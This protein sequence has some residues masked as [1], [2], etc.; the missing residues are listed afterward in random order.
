M[1]RVNYLGVCGKLVIF[2]SM[3]GNK[4][5]RR[6]VLQ[7]LFWEATLRCNMECRHCGSDCLKVS[8]TADMP[9]ADFLPV[10]DEIKAAQPGRLPY[11]FTLGGEPLV[12]P[13]ILRCGREITERGF[14]WGM[15]SN[16]MLIDGEMMRAL[17]ANGLRSLAID[18]D[19][20]AAEHNWLR[21]NDSAF[22]RVF[23][24]ISHI[25]KAPHLIWDVITCVHSRNIA[26]LPE[27]R[28]MLVDAGVKRWRCFTIVPMGRAK[29]NPEL[30]LTDSQFTELMEF[31][32]QTRA[33]GQIDLS[34]SCEGY[35]GD[36][37]MRVRPY[38]FHCQAGEAVA[39]IRGNGDISGCLSIRSAY[40]QGNIYRDS[41]WD[42]WTSRF[43]FCRD[44]EWMRTGV[45]ADCDVFDR[46]QGNGMHLR[47]DDGS[48]MHCNYRRLQGLSAMQD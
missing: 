28:R 21:R 20:T 16:A 39:S 36:Y 4:K 47:R 22:D 17:S 33:G 15:V 18:V 31:I 10:L 43:G 12:R 32:V 34:Y 29:D 11:V 35:L 46:C 38:P 13:D 9:L 14:V 30:L 37:E 41:F 5:K 8:E 42:V 26:V 3:N 24:A 45:C 6:Y 40:T 48:L 1:S 25:R 27:L 23:D 2:A 7:Q 19:G 44:R